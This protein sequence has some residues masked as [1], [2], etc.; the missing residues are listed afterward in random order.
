MDWALD[1]A[2]IT[3]YCTSVVPVLTETAEEFG[4]G[5]TVVGSVDD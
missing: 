1:C 4:A 2:I 5:V 3:A